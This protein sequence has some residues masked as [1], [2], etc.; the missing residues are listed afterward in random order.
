MSRRESEVSAAKPRTVRA[1]ACVSPDGHVTAQSDTALAGD[2]YRALIVPDVRCKHETV[3]TTGPFTRW[4][5]DCGAIRFDVDG[6]WRK[7]R[8]LRAARSRA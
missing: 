1:V 4:C 5:G 2:G 8:I 6:R 3:V 7:P